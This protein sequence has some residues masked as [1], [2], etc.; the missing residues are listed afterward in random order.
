MNSAS[1]SINSGSTKSAIFA[2]TS[3]K[4]DGQTTTD[5]KS[6]TSKREGTVTL[7]SS[8]NALKESISLG[9]TP[10]PSRIGDNGESCTPYAISLTPKVS[11]NPQPLKI[12]PGQSVRITVTGMAGKEY[13]NGP[14]SMSI[15]ENWI[16]AANYEHIEVTED[17]WKTTDTELTS[18]GQTWN[19]GQLQ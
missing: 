1:I 11:A 18:G 19:F 15:M 9:V 6:N 14:Y 13:K 16:K 5:N 3:F 10:Q 4:Y 7:E 17:V 8:E 2:C 12:G